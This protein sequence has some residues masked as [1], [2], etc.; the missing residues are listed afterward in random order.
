MEA[1]SALRI[2]RLEK[3]SIVTNPAKD[4]LERLKARIL[5]QNGTVLDT[6]EGEL[7]L[8]DTD[9]QGQPRLGPV[10]VLRNIEEGARLRLA[11]P[12]P[13]T[14]FGSLSGQVLGAYRVRAGSLLSG[15][16]EG[17]RYVEIVRDLG[18]KTD[19]NADS[20][21]AFEATNDPGF[22]A[23]AQHGL[24]KLQELERH[25]QPQRE[26]IARQLLLRSLRDVPYNIKVFAQVGQ[27]VKTVFSLAPSRHSK[28]I[29]LDLKSLLRHL[30]IKTGQGEKTS[31]SELVEQFKSALKETIVESLSL[32]NSGGMGSTLR[33]QRGHEVYQ[34]Q[35]EALYNYLFPKL[36]YLWLKVGEGFAQT[37]VDRLSEAPMILK[38]EG[39]LAP[40]FQLEYPRWHFKV[41]GSKVLSEKIADC[42]ISCQ[43]GSSPDTLSLNYTHVSGENWITQTRELER[44]AVRN[45]RII[46]K[47]G[48]VYL[49]DET[50]CLFGP[51]LEQAQQ[52]P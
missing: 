30:I 52:A 4:P 25:Q 49:G 10:L 42:N 14:V 32:A 13:V 39:Q 44:A 22:L 6:V 1:P 18:S 29:E 8:N 35:T 28:E 46:L 24:E 48:H 51:T 38:V 12:R 34:A 23:Q 17:A 50:S 41:V 15:R 7:E 20:W 26:Y 16:I 36:I 33:K 45:C 19:S 47:N 37:V 11:R 27:E 5:S 2:A 3:R 43:A 9:D 21:I 40:F 31:H